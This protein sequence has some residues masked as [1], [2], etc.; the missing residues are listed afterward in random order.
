MDLHRY[1]TSFADTLQDKRFRK[2]IL[3]MAFRPSLI[4]ISSNLE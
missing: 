1:K 4:L 2:E 3:S